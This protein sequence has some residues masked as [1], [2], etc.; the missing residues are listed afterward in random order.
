M[1]ELLQGNSEFSGPP[2][3]KYHT[4]A[5]NYGSFT[6]VACCIPSGIARVMTDR[7]K[8]CGSNMHA[9]ALTHPPIYTRTHIHMLTLF[10]YALSFPLILGLCPSHI[11]CFFY[12]YSP[13]MVE[14][15]RASLHFSGFKRSYMPSPSPG[16][17]YTGIHAKDTAR[18][19]QRASGAYYN[20]DNFFIDEGAEHREEETG[21][22][23][24]EE[25]CLPQSGVGEESDARGPGAKGGGIDLAEKTLDGW[26][27][28]RGEHSRLVIGEAEKG[29]LLTAPAFPRPLMLA[30]GTAGGGLLRVEAGACADDEHTPIVSWAMAGVLGHVGGAGVGGRGSVGGSMMDSLL[31]CGSKLSRRIVPENS[32]IVSNE[33]AKTGQIADAAESSRAR[34]QTCANTPSHN[35]D[36]SKLVGQGLV[37]AVHQFVYHSYPEDDKTANEKKGRVHAQ[38]PQSTRRACLLRDPASLPSTLLP[39]LYPH[40][41]EKAEEETNRFFLLGQAQV[42]V[43]SAM[44]RQVC[45]WRS[46]RERVG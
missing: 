43:A 29:A 44:S 40:N 9:R 17:F 41:V 24:T 36:S 22:G 3:R 16:I 42:V 6:C 14:R 27:L 39:V 15:Q 13:V 23:E 7:L 26:G 35:P 8:C 19:T 25:N 21:D 30:G 2:P 1:S 38:Q 46:S 11:P 32:T 37:G 18:D 12:L 45:A 33:C 28:E 34:L 5:F 31:I 4:C 20:P 10:S